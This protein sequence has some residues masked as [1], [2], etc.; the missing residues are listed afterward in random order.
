MQETLKYEVW[1]AAC[2]RRAA[3]RTEGRPARRMLQCLPTAL[4]STVENLARTCF[5]GLISC[6]AMT[7][8][9]SWQRLPRTP[10]V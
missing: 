1:I 10:A 4:C 9:W 6:L 3:I 7:G 5:L 2:V 8:V